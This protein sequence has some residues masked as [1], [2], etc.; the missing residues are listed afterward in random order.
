MSAEI[1]N[2]ELLKYL[3]YGGLPRVYQSDEP[4]DDLKAYCR[5]Y[6]NEE[7]KMEAAVRNYDRFVRFMETMALSNGQEINYAS[8]SSDSGAP[9]RTIEGHIEV[10]KDTLI[11][12]ELLPFNKTVKRKATTKSKFYFFDCGVAN[13]F[14]GRLP[15][16]DNS[17]DL[18][19][20]FEQFMIQE[21]RAYLSYSKINKNITCW[22][23]RDYEV[24][25]VI[26][27]DIAIEFKFSKQFKPEFLHG[28]QALKEER[29]L[30]KY[31]LVGRFPSGGETQGI[32]YFNYADF[33]KKLW[34]GEII[35]Q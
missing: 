22:R 33:L 7:I 23:A 20:S 28:L 30:K 13:Y 12:F 31:F 24:D 26:G 14:A 35:G 17:S 18:G 21:I 25:L 8:L 2:F 9:A 10:L 4:V 27:K 15:M 19:V 3:K 5:T 11:G 34:L 6:L 32:E 1:T 29:L 16:A